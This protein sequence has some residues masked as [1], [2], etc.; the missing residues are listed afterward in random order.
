MFSD[1]ICQHANTHVNLLYRTLY[2]ANRGGDACSDAGADRGDYEQLQQR[3]IYG[4][5][6]YTCMYV[7]AALEKERTQVQ[8]LHEWVSMRA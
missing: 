6:D 7:L 4:I 2:K 3:P 5:C 8:I 1:L